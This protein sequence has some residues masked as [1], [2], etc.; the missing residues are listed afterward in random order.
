VRVI[1]IVTLTNVLPNL[2]LVLL[3]ESYS[4]N[5]RS[6]YAYDTWELWIFMLLCRSNS[7][8]GWILLCSV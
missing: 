3:K 8:C 1:A 6:D 4:M 5:M 7:C 2:S